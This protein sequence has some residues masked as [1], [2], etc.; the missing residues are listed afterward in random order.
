MDQQQKKTLYQLIA[1]TL[2]CNPGQLS[3]GTEFG[4]D[5]NAS[6]LEMERLVSLIER[7]F[8]IELSATKPGELMNIGQLVTDIEEAML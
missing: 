8:D 5:L 7:E 3:Q 1:N 4:A 6:P 2:G